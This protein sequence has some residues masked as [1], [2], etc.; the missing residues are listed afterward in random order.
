M[1]TQTI[2]N[3]KLLRISSK[4]M[5]KKKRTYNNQIMYVEHGTFTPLV[6]SLTGGE[7][8]ETSMFHKNIAQK[9]SEKNEEKY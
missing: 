2:T 3:V 6:F 8:P 5:K 7:G 4:N 1:S 9:H